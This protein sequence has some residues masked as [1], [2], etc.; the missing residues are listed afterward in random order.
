MMSL[1]NHPG[2]GGFEEDGYV[3]GRVLFDLGR[4]H[5]W[6]IQ[7]FVPEACRIHTERYV[8]MGFHRFLPGLKQD[9]G[10]FVG[11]SFL[12]YLHTVS[13]L[14]QRITDPGNKS[15]PNK[16]LVHCSSPDKTRQDALVRID[17]KIAKCWPENYP[18]QSDP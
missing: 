16:P 5:T 1:W 2:V 17:S 15:G 11:P 8:G 13:S 18:M 4:I 7:S 10:D 14:K 9:L 6:N 12:G 3:G